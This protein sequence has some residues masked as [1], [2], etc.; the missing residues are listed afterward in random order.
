M[1]LDHARLDARVALTIERIREIEALCGL[2]PENREA[3]PALWEATLKGETDAVE[4]V[5]G[6]A[7]RKRDMA[8]LKDAVDRR[9]DELT[10]RRER[11]RRQE[12]KARHAIRLVM[13]AAGL[14]ALPAHPEVGVSLSKGRE[15]V[16][17]TSEAEVPAEFDKEP[18]RQIDM[19]R[20]REAVKAG[21]EVPGVA[22]TTGE[23]VVTIR[24]R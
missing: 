21:R 7:R 8:D 19:A 13:E 24:W 10:A 5:V 22:R 6:L 9:V 20:V 11:F 23:P 4:L 2:T 12:E 15:R 14:K 17:V 16:E 1:P 18:T 3:D